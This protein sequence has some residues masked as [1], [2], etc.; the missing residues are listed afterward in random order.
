VVDGELVLD[1]SV[2]S[3]RIGASGVRPLGDCAGGDTAPLAFE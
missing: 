1:E 3:A 2:S